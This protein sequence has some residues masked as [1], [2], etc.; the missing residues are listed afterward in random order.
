MLFTQNE[1][2]IETIGLYQF[3]V[4]TFHN[5]S[6]RDEVS[7]NTNYFMDQVE[8]RGV[9]W[10]APKSMWKRISG[11]ITAMY[12][13][14]DFWNRFLYRFRYLDSDIFQPSKMELVEHF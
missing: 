1:E 11:C 9:P 14:L 10:D 13:F 8:I 2:N 12:L 4:H 6:R 5:F 3:P 7:T